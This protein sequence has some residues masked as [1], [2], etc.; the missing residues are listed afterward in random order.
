MGS[1]HYTNTNK[2]TTILLKP[3]Y[4]NGTI[5]YNTRITTLLSFSQPPPLLSKS[6]RHSKAM[7]MWTPASWHVQRIP[8]ITH[9]TLQPQQ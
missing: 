1:S 9:I 4:A 7:N 8:H 5:K 2:H 3:I 6:H